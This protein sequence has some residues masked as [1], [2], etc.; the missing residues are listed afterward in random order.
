MMFQALF[1]KVGHVLHI[2]A[3]TCSALPQY[4]ESGA[5]AVTL[6][7]PDPQVCRALR[8]STTP[9]KSVNVIEAAVT[10]EPGLVCL[11]RFAFSDLNSLRQPTGL[12]ELFPG[13]EPPS[14]EQVNIQSP[15]VLLR[16]LGLSRKDN[17]IL[18]IEAPGEAQAIL[19]ALDGADLL[20]LF[21]TLRIREGARALYKGAASITEISQWLKDRDYSRG[22]HLNEEDPDHPVLTVG[23]DAGAAERRRGTAKLQK[24]DIAL[25]E[26]QETT[27]AQHRKIENLQTTLAEA[28]KAQQAAQQRVAKKT[29]QQQLAKA[30]EAEALRKGK[31]AAVQHEKIEKQQKTTAHDLRI[32]IST[33]AALQ[34]DI[35]AL[36]SRYKQVQSE[37]RALETLLIQVTQSLGKA[38]DYLHHLS[39]PAADAGPV[40]KKPSAKKPVDKPRP[41]K[42]KS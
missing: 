12:T 2:G 30:R 41:P 7:E 39:P 42:G 32:A 11:N 34:A 26:L 13:L 5:A 22:W 16:G 4:L 31:Q 8:E 23:F 35:E 19:Q 6:V 29:E 15:H 14:R 10:S 24:A 36:Q 21:Q 20:P 1:G 27:A 37:K 18:V 17:N 3:G 33:Q 25:A 38:S 28:T 40:K 9:H